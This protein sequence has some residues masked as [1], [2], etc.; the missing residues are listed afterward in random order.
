MLTL[1]IIIIITFDTIG[2]LILLSKSMIIIIYPLKQY[3]FNLRKKTTEQLKIILTITRMII[4]TMVVG[5]NV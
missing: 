3:H 4:I 1:L 5:L 2:K